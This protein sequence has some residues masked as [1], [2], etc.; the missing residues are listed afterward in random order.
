[1]K[2]LDLAKMLARQSGISTSAAA[3]RLDRLVSDIVKSLRR[4]EAANLPGLG[5]FRPGP[6][7][8]FVFEGARRTPRKRK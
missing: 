8:H 2:K 7:T 1:M 4:G 6:V 3:D 5:K